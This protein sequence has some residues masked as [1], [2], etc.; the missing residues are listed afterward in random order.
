M[1]TEKSKKELHKVKFLT[2]SISFH[3][4]HISISIFTYEET[5]TEGLTQSQTKMQLCNSHSI[6]YTT[7]EAN[8]V[9][10]TELFTLVKNS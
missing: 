7:I 9:Y 10:S 2:N 8:Q 1:P 4:H 6:Y 3:L 5:E